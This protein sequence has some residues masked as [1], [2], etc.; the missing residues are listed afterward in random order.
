MLLSKGAKTK[1]QTNQ[2][3]DLVKFVFIFFFNLISLQTDLKCIHMLIFKTYELMGI[4]VTCQIF[5]YIHAMLV[6]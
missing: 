5:S 3:A 2:C 4:M 6:M 1:T